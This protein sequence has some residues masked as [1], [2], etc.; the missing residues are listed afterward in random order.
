ME[1]DYPETLYEG[2]TTED[3]RHW[4]CKQCFEELKE[5]FHWK[6]EE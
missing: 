4:I 5:M 6:L 1:D 2:Y 3:G